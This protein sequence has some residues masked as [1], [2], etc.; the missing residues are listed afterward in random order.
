MPQ[1]AVTTFNSI[2]SAQHKLALLGMPLQ[3]ILVLAAGVVIVVALAPGFK[4]WRGLTLGLVALLLFFGEIALVIFHIRLYQLCTV[5]DPGTGSVMG[6][7]AVPLWIESEKLYVWAISV[8]VLG[9]IMRRQREDLLPGAMLITA[10]LTIGAAV[11][12][13]PFTNPLPDF[14][15]QYVGYLQASVSGIP[16]AATGAYEGMFNA[17][18]YYYNAWYMWVHPPLL[19]FAYGCFALSFVATLRMISEKHSSFETTAYRWAR[20]GYLSLTFGMLLGF[21]WAI[22]AWGNESWWWSGKVNMSIMMWLLYTA[23]LHARLYLRRE[24]MWRVVA[25]LSI[26]SFVVLVLTY[27]ATYVI[28]GAHSYALAPAARVI[29]DVAIACRGGAA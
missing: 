18:K 25:V 29:A 5:V 10:L 11:W 2:Q 16:Q 26:L 24:H 27:I 7:V 1:N 22:L 3:I 23:Y 19:F 17:M 20:M 14:T 15:Q 28:P 4:R 6:R 21:P 8:A 13:K 12:G 9:T